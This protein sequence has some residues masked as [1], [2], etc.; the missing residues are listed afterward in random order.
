M[1]KESTLHNVTS[2]CTNND[3]FVNQTFVL[4]FERSW[5]SSDTFVGFVIKLNLLL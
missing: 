1:G 3:T 5:L 4:W 2:H